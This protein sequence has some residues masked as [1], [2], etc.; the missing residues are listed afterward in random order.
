MNQPT[1]NKCRKRSQSQEANEQVVKTNRLLNS[2]LK[3][4][5]KFIMLQLAKMSIRN[6]QNSL[7]CTTFQSMNMEK[8]LEMPSLNAV[9]VVSASSLIKTTWA[10]FRAHKRACQLPLNLPREKRTTRRQVFIT[11]SQVL[12]LIRV[13]TLMTQSKKPKAAK[14]ASSLT[15][16]LIL[17]PKR[18]SLRNQLPLSHSITISLVS[19][20]NSTSK[21]TKNTT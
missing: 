21:L 4:L 6:S 10:K 9:V 2:Q 3:L 1:N 5:I 11:H 18:N 14:R 12:I 15:M 16:N 19:R 13:K 8:S 20:V 7:P 17:I